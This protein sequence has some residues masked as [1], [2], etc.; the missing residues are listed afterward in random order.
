M[1]GRLQEVSMYKCISTESN[2]QSI[3]SLEGRDIWQNI[4]E[5]AF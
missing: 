3:R 4:E 2:C 1:Q 5:V